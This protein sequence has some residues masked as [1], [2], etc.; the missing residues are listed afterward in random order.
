MGK[1][2]HEMN[3]KQRF[4][5]L[6][7]LMGM[8][9]RAPIEQR[10]LDFVAHQFGTCKKSVA[11]LWQQ[12]KTSRSVGKIDEEEIKNK[13]HNCSGVTKYDP[14]QVKEAVKELRFKDKRTIRSLVAKLNIPKTTIHRLTQLKIIV[15][16]VSHTKPHLTEGN[17]VCCLEYALQLRA[18]NKVEYQD[19]YNYVHVDKKWFLL[20]DTAEA[21][22]LT[23]DK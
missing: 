5:C 15:R 12:A 20:T 18:G 23:P 19:L 14:E 17:K 8:S 2:K 7:M 16:Q 13:R 9:N 21:Y 3:N 22:Y 11:R 1:K 10:D 6:A 4:A